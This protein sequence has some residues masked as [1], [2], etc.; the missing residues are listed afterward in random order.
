MGKKALVA[1][2]FGTTYPAAR[3]A[4]EALE[5]T[6]RDAFPE[7]D[8]YRAFTSDMVRRKIA[9]EEGTIVPNPAELLG[10]LADA[11]YGEVRCQSLHVIPGLEYE[12]LLAQLGPY[13]TRF[14]ELAVGKPLLWETGDY[15]RLTRA[16]L[17]TMPRLADDEAYVFMGHGT[18]H[19]ANAAYALTEN[20]FRYAGAERVYVATVEGFPHLDYILARLHGREVAHVHLAPLMIVAGDHAQCDLAGAGE[21]SWKSRLEAEGYTVETHL[22]GLGENPA[23]GALFAG[24]CR[25]AE[26]LF[27]APTE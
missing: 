3:R 22:T 15:L 2:S 26:P 5:R 14:D 21:D 1:V 17:E 23:V 6:L 25:A 4:I 8:F 7:Y 24:H 11:G 20:A 19:P 13:R 27:A 12:K 10:R 18:E 16:L 9:R